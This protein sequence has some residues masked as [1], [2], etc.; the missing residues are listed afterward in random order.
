MPLLL[1]LR[2]KL[3]LLANMPGAVKATD[4][5]RCEHPPTDQL[6]EFWSP[7]PFSNP[8]I[9]CCLLDIAVKYSTF[10]Q[11]FFN[12]NFLTFIFL[13]A[14]SFNCSAEHPP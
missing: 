14:D 2:K 4:V 12:D 8:L 10:R 5:G 1:P 3:L 6:N 11:S 13:S 7:N 9:F